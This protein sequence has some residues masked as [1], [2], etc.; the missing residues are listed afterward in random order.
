MS[1]VEESRLEM[2]EKFKSLTPEE[3]VEFKKEFDQELY[4][5]L[6]SEFNKEIARSIEA[7]QVHKADN[8][9]LV[10]GELQEQEKAFWGVTEKDNVSEWFK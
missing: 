1:T 3:Q 5:I 10:F 9:A 6:T 7:G 4:N 2:L 8:G